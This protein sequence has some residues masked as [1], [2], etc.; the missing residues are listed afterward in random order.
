MTDE[1]EQ[2]PQQSATAGNE[3]GKQS[4]TA[5][6]GADKRVVQAWDLQRRLGEVVALM[7]YSDSHEHLFLVDLKWAVFP[8][9]KLR[10]Y[11]IMRDQD[12]QAVAYVS[13]A[14]VNEEVEV[15]LSAGKVKLRPPEWRC[16]EQAVI[17]DMLS[18]LN[19]EEEQKRILSELKAKVFAGRVLKAL[20]WDAEKNRLMLQEV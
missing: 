11:R 1:R 9:L 12:K 17:M 13:W 19:S 8:P 6:G 3:A 20:R 2:V 10:Q 18:G 14:W 16:G 4:A 15:R 7:S 5:A